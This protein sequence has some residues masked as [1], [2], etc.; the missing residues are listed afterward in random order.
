MPTPAI[1]SKFLSLRRIA[2]AGVSR[3]GQDAGSLIYERLQSSGHEVFAVN[4]Q[5]GSIGGEPFRA[6]LR[7]IPGGVEGVVMVTTPQATE[8]L[9]AECIELGIGHVWMHRSLGSSVS[10]QAVQACLENGIAVILG[11]C[12]LM[13]QEPVDLGHRC[14]RWWFQ[15]QG[16]A[17]R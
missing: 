4:P 10:E 5:P 16:V 14:L 9:V 7:E 15:R 13:F 17:P 6:N 8:Q 3:S 11:G 12:P 2:V 1:V